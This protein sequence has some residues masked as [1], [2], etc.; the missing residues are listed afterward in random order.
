[1]SLQIF[2]L[3]FTVNISKTST[4]S[5]GRARQKRSNYKHAD[6]FVSRRTAVLKGIF[7]LGGCAWRGRSREK[8]PA[9]GCPTRCHPRR[10]SSLP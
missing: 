8:R 9:E 2:Y 3:F 1:M 7:S 5:L 6:A 10:L 4:E